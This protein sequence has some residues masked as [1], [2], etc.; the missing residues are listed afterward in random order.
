MADKVLTD[1]IKIRTLFGWYWCFLNDGLI[2][3][4]S[5]FMETSSIITFLSNFWYMGFVKRMLRT[6]MHIY[7]GIGR[8]KKAS[9]NREFTVMSGSVQPVSYYPDPISLP[10]EISKGRPW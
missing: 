5:I 8:K 1:N 10:G 7:R 4:K 9:A 2:G 3:K 6:P